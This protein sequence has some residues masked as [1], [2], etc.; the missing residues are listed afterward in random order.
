MTCLVKVRFISN[1]IKNNGGSHILNDF[2]II[3]REELEKLKQV[4]PKNVSVELDSDGDIHEYMDRNREFTTEFV[5]YLYS[6]RFM[7]DN[8]FQEIMRIG[9]PK[10]KNGASLSFSFAKTGHIFSV[11]QLIKLRNPTGYEN[12]ET[13]AHWMANRGHVFTV[14]E[15]L[16]LGNPPDLQGQTVA[17]WMVERNN[18]FNADEIIRLGNPYDSLGE[19]LAHY[20]AYHGGKFTIEEILKMKNPSDNFGHTVAHILVETDPHY[21]TIDELLQLGDPINDKGESI[22]SMMTSRGHYFTDEDYK[23]LNGIKRQGNTA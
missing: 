14:D 19:T 17:H 16:Q 9:D 4:M 18:F 22:S 5:E 11:E 7:P 20:V 12:E 13:V 1:D 23:K 3:N 6:L 8:V 2:S 21:F 10:D 15:L